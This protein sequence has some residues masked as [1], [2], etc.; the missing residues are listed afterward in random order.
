VNRNLFLV[1]TFL[2][3]FLWAFRLALPSLKSEIS[4]PKKWPK[5][6]YDVSSKAISEEGFQLGRSLF[7]DPILSRDSTISC[8][9]CHLQY[10]GFA[11]VD[12]N[13]SHGIEGRKGTRNAPALINLAWKK[14][15][16]WDGGVNHIEV[17]AINPLTHPAEMDNTLPE[18]LRRLMANEDYRK[19]FQL[20]YGTGEITTAKLMNALSQFTRSLISANSK[21]D[22]VMRKEKGVAFTEQEQNG[23]NLFRQHCV[24]CHQEP[25]FTSHQFKSNGLPS[26]PLLNDLGRFDIT[27][28]ESDSYLFMIPTLR[29]IEF[30]FPYMHDGRFRKLKDVL[31]HYSEKIDPSNRHLSHELNGPMH[32]SDKEQK[33]MLAFLYTLTD[34]QFLYNPRFS[35]PKK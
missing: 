12:H 29:N 25:L 3:V 14:F 35:F 22:Q 17:Q 30:T 28:K 31:L 18:V 23:L 8:T 7:Y 1:F 34:K 33:D 16:H 11:H 15:F 9:T 32:L 27:G 21:Y 19:R 2:S 4:I 5:P 6:V 10:T 24:A 26:D 13:V 20:V